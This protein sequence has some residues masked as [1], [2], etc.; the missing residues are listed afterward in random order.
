MKDILLSKLTEILNIN[1]ILVG[2]QLAER[3]H[4]IWATNVPLKAKA[5]VFPKTTKEVSQIMKICDELDQKVVIHGGLTNLVGG[6]ETSSDK[7]VI[8]LEKM[9]EI[10]ELDEYSRTITVGAGVILEEVQKAA[11]QKDLLF[12][13]NFG[14][15]GSAQMGGI[16]SSN[17][18]GLRVLRFGMT[19]NLVLG[20][21]V[22]LADGTIINSIKKIIKDN[23]GFDLKHLFIG[24]EGTLGIVTRVVLKLVEKPKSRNSLLAGLDDYEDV[25]KLLKFMDGGLAGTLS[26]FELMHR[27]YYN[28]ATTAPSLMKAPLPNEY[29]YYV[30]IENLGSDQEKDLLILEQ[31]MEEAFENKL[32]QDA[33]IAQ[34]ASDLNW[35]W[36][37]REDVH[38]AVI[39]CKYDQHFDISLPTALIGEV[40]DKII[41]ELEKLEDVD[42]VY[43]FGHV[44][45][46]NVHFI[47]GKANDTDM[48][49]D[50]INDIVYTPLKS[51]GGSISA[52]HGIGKHKKKYLSYSRSES[53]IALMKKL[54]DLMDPKCLLNDGNI[55]DV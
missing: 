35:L 45:D 29:K 20:L 36:T 17:A 13:L 43:L 25:L 37:I 1:R 26:G 2:P 9:N 12:P 51:I 31:L 8:S 5:L 38:A 11:D 4:H 16:V 39:R 32:I 34:G 21:E 23:S 22:V 41:K 55:F 10:E 28:A 47:V 42:Q 54:K 27:N 18:G 7:L 24:A 3:T 50:Q 14:A 49:K 19:R 30:L 44:A 46:G 40:T 53:E 6:T 15:K 48:L 52:E 33:V